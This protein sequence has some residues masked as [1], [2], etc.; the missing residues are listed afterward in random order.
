MKKNLLLGIGFC[1]SVGV[2]AQTNVHA[3]KQNTIQKERS[4]SDNSAVQFIPTV[5][6]N[7]LTKSIKSG[8][9]ALTKT[10]FTSSRNAFGVIVSEANCLNANQATNTIAFCHRI[11]QDWSPPNVE[12]GF[13]QTTF[14]TNNGATW[15]SLLLNQDPINKSRYPSS[16]LY[17]P[18]GNTLSSGLYSVVS[19]PFT[20]GTAG[21]FGNYFA[22]G[23]L[24][25]TNVNVKT[26]LNASGTV[27][28]Q[29]FARI[30]MQSTDT[31]VIVTGA[32]MRDPEATTGLAQG[33]R[34]VSI[35]YGTY[36]GAGNFNW[37]VDSIKNL[38]KLDINNIPAN[39]GDKGSLQ[40]YTTVSTAWS[41]DGSIGYIIFTGVDSAATGDQLAYQPVV[42]KTTNGG[43]NWNK[44]PLGNYSTLPDIAA[45]LTPTASGSKKAWYSQNNGFAT[46]VDANGNLHIVCVVL[47][48]SS[49]GLDSL[50]FTWNRNDNISYIYDTYTTS[51]GWDARLVDSLLC[52]VAT[53]NSPFINSADASSKMQLDA[54]IQVS[55]TADRTKLFYVWNDTDPGLAAGE[56]AFPDIKVKGYNLLTNLST[57]TSLYF[58][59][60][61]DYYMY[62]SRTALT[63]GTTYSIPCTSSNIRSGTDAITP[64]DHYY[65]SGI[66]FNESEFVV[67]IEESISSNGK[68][69]ISQNYPNPFSKET[70]VTVTLKESATVS[71]EVFNAIGQ[72]VIAL[73][74]QELTS[75]TH[76][77]KIDGMN[78]TSGMYFYTVKTGN[79][80]VTRKMIVK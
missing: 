49:D 33:Y 78:L 20:Q 26:D 16:A 51:T 18:A 74:P 37:T 15:D 5:S 69:S 19:G 50:G 76:T 73:T 24:D 25:K 55:M 70:A 6:S 38:F 28:V 59:D 45:R 80:F 2:T 12:V 56:N 14:T 60:N 7:R 3:V 53:T 44:M 66:E 10:K 58:T 65:L 64:F 63:N 9:R 21:W 42:Y 61:S 1:I 11:S 62:A 36:N 57:N 52:K 41:Q 43:T 34:G 31:K 29:H 39:A 13:I 48:A 54:R 68:V 47:S 27:P 23:K 46:C 67:G 72:K 32:L 75:G 22:S 17:N 30:N 71:L 4:F 35:N 8:T 79:T 77:L 40:V